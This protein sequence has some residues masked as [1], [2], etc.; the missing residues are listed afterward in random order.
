MI[1][2]LVVAFLVYW[3]I[4][5]KQDLVEKSREGAEAAA[6]SAAKKIA[7]KV[8]QLKIAKD[9]SAEI[10]NGKLTA[11]EIPG[12]FNFEMENNPEISSLSIAYLEEFIPYRLSI[13]VNL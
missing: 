2:T 3:H 7:D 1:N 13:G 9:M 10:S 5:Q 11:E 6:Q 12:R 8:A 4:D